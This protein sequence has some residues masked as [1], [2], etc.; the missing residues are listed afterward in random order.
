M[1]SEQKTTNQICDT[2]LIPKLKKNNLLTIN[3]HQISSLLTGNLL[4]K[5]E[6][7]LIQLNHRDALDTLS[8]EYVIV[9]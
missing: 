5:S 8:R 7:V 4:V 1:V 6:Y 3:K 2:Y 9:M